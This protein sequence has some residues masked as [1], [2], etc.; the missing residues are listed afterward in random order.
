[1]QKLSSLAMFALVS[2]SI[3]L[4]T[5]HAAD[6][7]RICTPARVSLVDDC[8]ARLSD[9]PALPR[10]AGTSDF[11]QCPFPGRAAMSI[12][13]HWVRNSLEYCALTKSVYAR[14]TTAAE[15]MPKHYGAGEWIVFLDADETILDNSVY[16]RE[17]EACHQ[18]WSRASWR[19]WVHDK[20]AGRVPGAAAFTRRVHDLGGVVVIV[21]N[22]D[23]DQD[24]RTQENLC[25]LGIWFDYEIG[26]TDNHSDKADRWRHMVVL[27]ARA[28][29]AAPKAAM[30]VGDQMSDLAVLNPD[31]GIDRAM[32]QS[33]PGDGIGARAFLLPNP[34]YGTWLKNPNH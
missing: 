4:E 20:M 10:V 3:Q 6:G 24:Q 32:G 9:E 26:M 17:R 11:W 25:T 22:R 1:M 28:G 8:Q 23:E 33:D 12:A 2:L 16:Q 21:T 34:M 19:G 18:D 31:G 27:V 5:V 15:D 29:V 13:N 30:W 7:Q 14:A